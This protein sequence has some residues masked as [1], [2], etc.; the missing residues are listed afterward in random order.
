MVNGQLPAFFRQLRQVLAAQAARA[1]PDTQLLE[2]FIHHRDE[3]AFEVLVWR[4][5]PMV[6]NVCERVLRHRQEAE[7]AFQATF[8][9][10]VRK[11]RSINR[12]EALGSWLY[13][14]AYRLALQARAS[15]SK[16]ETLSLG[17]AEEQ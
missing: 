2:R 6:W 5:G 4:H 10:L 13:K 16:R 11:V 7:D 12:R 14:V 15:L 9:L 8:L 1:V 17:S 3:A